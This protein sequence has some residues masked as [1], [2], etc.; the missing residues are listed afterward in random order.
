MTTPTRMRS[1]MAATPP[2]AA[3][4]ARPPVEHSVV[5]AAPEPVSHVMGTPREAFM[6]GEL[7]VGSGCEVGSGS[8]GRDVLVRL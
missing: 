7:V 2:S 1:K 3:A 5:A 4:V 6:H 8:I